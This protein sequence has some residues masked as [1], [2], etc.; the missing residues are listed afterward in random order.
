[1]RPRFGSVLIDAAAVLLHKGGL[2]GRKRE[3]ERNWPACAGVA[4]RRCRARTTALQR[5]PRLSDR[6]ALSRQGNWGRFTRYCGDILSEEAAPVRSC[7]SLG[8]CRRY[9]CR[10]PG[11]QVI[12]CEHCGSSGKKALGITAIHRR[13]LGREP[14][15]FPQWLAK[16]RIISG[17]SRHTLRTPSGPF[18]YACN[19]ATSRCHR[20]RSQ[21][22]SRGH[23]SCA[24]RTEGRR[25]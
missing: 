14:L 20:S 7:R 1:M 15:L 8:V 21:R 22:T 5:C 4:G 2:R 19:P 12:R 23:R 9:R 17:W 3:N 24:S 16:R 13:G 11:T 6:M 18:H 25:L 10:V